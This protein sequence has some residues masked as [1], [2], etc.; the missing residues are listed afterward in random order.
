MN[1]TTILLDTSI[2]KLVL[3]TNDPL[4]QPFLEKIERAYGYI[5]Y[6][7]RWGYSDRLVK[8]YENTRKTQ[9]TLKNDPNGYTHKFIIGRGW[10]SYLLGVLKDNISKENW[11]YLCKEVLLMPSYRETP[12]DNLRDYQNSDVLFLLKYRT[13]LLQVNTGWGKTEVLSTLANY[14][15]TALGLNVLVVTPGKKARDEIVKRIKSRFGL[16]LITEG[17]NQI[18]EFDSIITSGLMNSK[19]VKDQEKAKV[20]NDQLK[21]YQVVLSDEVEYCAS[22]DGGKYIFDH[23][24]G[25]IQ[26]IGVSGTADK[27]SAE[28]IS[29]AQGLSDVVT[30]N[31]DLITYF[32][33]ALVYRLPVNLEV[34]NITIKTK[35]LDNI[36]LPPIETIEGS[37]YYEITSMIWTYPDVIDILKKVIRKYPG[38]YIPINNL[39]KI[40]NKWTQQDFLGEFKMLLIYGKGYE[41]IDLDGTRTM[42]DLPTVCNLMT[43]GKVD[44]VLSTSSGFRALDLPSLSN[45]VLIA[46]KVAGVTLQ[47]IGRIARSRVMNIIHFEALG[48]RR[49]P[50][51]TKSA[52]L[53]DSMLKTYYHYCDINDIEILEDEL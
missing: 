13:A 50:L 37:V 53:R 41:Y 36:P 33:P 20:F 12:F 26:F 44:V 21:K 35:A 34:N 1:K 15:R 29:F 10:V 43:T 40:L 18:G 22:N 8:I 9:Y 2:N 46:G 7:K 4:I 27:E 6:Q 51:Y 30:R 42:C 48:G 19:R 3:Y 24:I 32:G 47:T 14:F 49:L 52:E 16:D 23:C 5:P 38:A 45:M 25:A 17:S 28:Q 11:D 39:T 31:R